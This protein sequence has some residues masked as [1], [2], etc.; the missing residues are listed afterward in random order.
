MKKILSLTLLVVSLAVPSAF[1]QGYF[2]FTTGKSQAWDGFTTPGTSAVSANVKVALLWAAANTA[3]PFQV[4]STSTSG[5]SSTTVASAGWDVTSA[6]ST[7][8][9]NSD[10][11][12]L[13]IN[14]GNSTLAVASTI[15]NGSITYNGG[16]SF[17]VTGT[18]PSTAYS[19]IL[20]GWNGTYADPTAAA[21]AGSAVGW[22]SVFQY[23]SVTTIGTP[24]NMAAQGAN[25]GV[26]VPLAVPEPGT[27]A[28]AGL[29][30]LSLLALR[31][32]N[33]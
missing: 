27:I 32:R 25:F 5:N 14:N 19:L 23:N 3:N 15:A 31:R 16:L 28:L 2:L 20:V 9:N 26:F 29:G 7:I 24:S 12:T 1:G 11:W 30:G 4:A 22:S 18:S 10:A 17:G 33:K 6:W 8:N 13:A 21:T